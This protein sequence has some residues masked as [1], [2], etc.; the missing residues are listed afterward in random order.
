[1]LLG[2][3]PSPRKNLLCA[4]TPRRRPTNDPNKQQPAAPNAEDSFKALERARRPPAPYP[5]LL[6]SHLHTQLHPL[7]FTHVIPIVGIVPDSE[8]SLR[9]QGH[10]E[11][12]S[13][14][15]NAPRRGRAGLAV[16]AHLAPRLR[17]CAA[18]SGLSVRNIPDLVIGI[19]C[20]LRQH[21]AP[22]HTHTRSDRS[23]P[24][25]GMRPRK[26]PSDLPR[27]SSA[28]IRAN[29]KGCAVGGTAAPGQALPGQDT[30][31]ELFRPQG[32][33]E[34]RGSRPVHLVS[35][36]AGPRHPLEGRERR[37]EAPSSPRRR[38][39]A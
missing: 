35:A 29:D 32:P 17:R 15:R 27:G 24:S 12:H 8:S 21:K 34:R 7:V 38:P 39:P 33:P 26:A 1:M 16:A 22:P 6:A 25:I 23:A 30:P 36:A 20:A 5:L 31:H 28:V 3:S 18:A 2:G 9:Q 10:H 19:S 13:V 37:P 4:D 11:I 14:L